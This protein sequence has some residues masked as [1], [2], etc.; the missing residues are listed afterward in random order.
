MLGVNHGA[1]ANFTLS[2]TGALN[3]TTA[4]GG[5]GDAH[6]LLG[7]ADSAADNTTNTFS[8]SGGTANIGRISLGGS[9]TTSVGVRSTLTLTGGTFTANQF[10]RLAAGD[11]N[12]A[13]INIGGTAQVTL[14]AFPTD[15]GSGA[16]AT[17]NFDGG[18]L[19]PLAASP[20]YAQSQRAK[21]DPID[22]AGIR[23]A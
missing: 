20:S 13:T 21:T 4:S 8:Q 7:R 5:S 1:S 22:A 15:R 2:G 9:G 10:T 11:G 12:V 14:P 16:T 6:L 17:I 18:S 3:L 23:Y 19:S